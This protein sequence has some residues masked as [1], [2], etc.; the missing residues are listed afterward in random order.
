VAQSLLLANSRE[1]FIMQSRLLLVGHVK[2]HIK[3]KQKENIGLR[4]LRQLIVSERLFEKYVHRIVAARRQ[5][6]GE[7]LSLLYV[8]NPIVHRS[9]F[10]CLASEK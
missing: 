7:K 3:S 9:A 1:M 8:D 5:K 2:V 4:G 10:R 6:G